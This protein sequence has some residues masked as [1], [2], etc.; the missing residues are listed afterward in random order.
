[1]KNFNLYLL[2]FL[3]YFVT[4]IIRVIPDGF[5][6]DS[7]VYMSMAVDIVDGSSSF[8]HL[9]F[10]DSLFNEFYE[11]PPLGVYTMALPFYLFGDTLLVD[12][13][14]G[15][16]SGVL[17]AF[18]I[19]GI[20]GLTLKEHKRNALLLSLFYFLAFPITGNSLE[21]NLLEIPAT[22]FILLSVYG[23]L[24]YASVLKHRILY[25]FA[26]SISLLTAF[27]VKGP[28]TLFPL[29]L[30]FF[31]ALVF[32]KEYSILEMIKFYLLVTLFISFFSF[33][34]YLYPASNHYLY[35]YFNNQIVSSID[36]SR[37][38]DERFKLTKQLIIDLSG[39][40]LVSYLA[41]LAGV[42]KLPK[43]NFSKL[44]WLFL[45][46]GL[47]GSLPL[48]VSPRQHDY[49]V[50]PSL[51][52]FAMALGVLFVEPVTALLKK[53]YSYRLIYLLNAILLIALLFLSYE[54][55]NANSRYKHFYS[56]FV[57]ANVE[58]VQGSKITACVD[59]GVDRD[60]FYYNIGLKANLKRHYRA[61]IT[62]EA[63]ENEYYLTTK[64]S[65]KSCAVEKSN[66]DYLGPKE[67]RYY[68]LYKKRSN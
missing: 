37:G 57:N 4:T 60:K 39:I 55:A 36:G 32:H 56:D 53:F 54:K 47:S 3:L 8:W 2:I 68:L 59:N 49:Y 66:Y 24:K 42:R 6:P 21:N 40:F 63:K 10:T 64:N 13:L 18:L 11:H 20:V 61:E 29:A 38:G 30:P 28:V 31:Y 46:I 17:L 34:L 43:L 52:F 50:F 62:E 33:L 48:E 22:F 14:Y 7:L 41:V 5:H 15:V 44:F 35:N 16:I 25:S 12:K 9:H 65:L 51:A 1:M 19:S 58:I 26:F 67:P 23:F 27:L 45:L